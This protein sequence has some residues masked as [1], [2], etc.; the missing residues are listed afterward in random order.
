MIIRELTGNFGGS[1]NF[2]IEKEPLGTAGGVKNAVG[3]YNNGAAACERPFLVMSGDALTDIDIS[4]LIACHYGSGAGVTIAA[5]RV[6]DVSGYG[7]IEADADGFVK[8]FVEKPAPNETN[9]NL[10]NCGIYIIDPDVLSLIPDGAYDFSRGLFPKMLERGDKINV[11]DIEDSYWRD[12]GSISSYFQA[13]I[14]ILSGK[15][16][17]N[18]KLIYGDDFIA[19]VGGE[20]YISPEAAIKGYAVIGNGAR[21][22]GSVT[23]E[24]CILWDEAVVSENLNNCIVVNDFCGIEYP[25][26]VNNFTVCTITD[27][28]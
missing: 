25:A 17:G 27:L 26:E 5:A 22:L 21:V 10:V 13:N 19:Y 8:T 16:E 14:D 24:N 23:L 12:I 7:V 20:S 9:S 4:A 18:D 15:C 28:P 6:D 11:F 3:A 1:F 2:V